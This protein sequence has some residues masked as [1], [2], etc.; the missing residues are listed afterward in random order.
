MDVEG[1]EP[2]TFPLSGEC[3]YRAELHVHGGIG[4]SRTPVFDPLHL[5][6]YE[7]IQL[8]TGTVA[9]FPAWQ[10][11]APGLQVYCRHLRGGHTTVPLSDV[12]PIGLL[13]PGF[14]TSPD[15]EP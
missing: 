5:G 2:S 3:S 15:G 4:G 6:F 11:Q 7:C 13:L 8:R 1:F 10:E 12:P 9:V 14:G